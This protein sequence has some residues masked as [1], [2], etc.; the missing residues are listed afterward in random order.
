[1]GLTRFLKKTDDG[2]IVNVQE[3]LASKKCDSL[4]F[5][6]LTWMFC[7]MIF[8]FFSTSGTTQINSLSSISFSTATS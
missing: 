6:L 1:M 7:K 8:E 2:L 4:T 5:G 3:Y